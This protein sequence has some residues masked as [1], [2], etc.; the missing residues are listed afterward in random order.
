M[1]GDTFKIKGVITYR[2][3][4]FTS[5]HCID[6]LELIQLGKQDTVFA[7]GEGRTL[8]HDLLYRHGRFVYEMTRRKVPLGI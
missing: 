7:G 6:A 4:L 3:G 5:A 2:V 8:V 1:P